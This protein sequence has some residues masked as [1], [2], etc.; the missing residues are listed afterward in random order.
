MGREQKGRRKG[1]GEGKGGKVLFFPL[2]HPL[3]STFLHSPHFLRGPNDSFALPKF[4][5]RR[6]GTLATQA[7]LAETCTYNKRVTS[8]KN[9]CV[10]G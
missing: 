1:V 2:P 4:R 7:K 3:P 5:S 6:A 9:V 8:P 10:G